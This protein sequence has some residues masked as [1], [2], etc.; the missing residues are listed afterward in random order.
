MIMNIDLD[1]AVAL[2]AI[3]A[4]VIVYMVTIGWWYDVGALAVVAIAAV[5]TAGIVKC[6]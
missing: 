1:K 6:P 4:I 2:T 3:W 5:A